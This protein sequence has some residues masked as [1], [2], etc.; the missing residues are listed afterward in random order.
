M[1]LA[2]AA[3]A[4]RLG[5]T[6]RA[7]FAGRTLR[8]CLASHARLMPGLQAGVMLRL[9]E[10]NGLAHWSH[11]LAGS[12]AG[13]AKVLNEGIAGFVASAV[14]AVTGM[15]PEQLTV[16]LPHRAEAPLRI[17][18]E[19]LG[20]RV[21][22]GARDAIV[23]TFDCRWLDRANLLLGPAPPG[24]DPVG[25]LPR[26]FES[27]AFS[28]S[29]GLADAARSLGLS[30]RSL[31]RRLG[32]LGTSFEA[33]VDAWR[34]RQAC[35]QLATASLPVGTIGRA[36]GYSDPAHFVRAFRRWEGRTPLAFRHA[37]QHAGSTASA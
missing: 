22:F 14:K 25:A 26:L 1:D 12:D 16:S 6:G 33:L 30:P 34:H 13:H 24:E 5:L 20:A 17:Y 11:R 9:E 18:E 3:D 23:W 29:L 21:T 8:E 31:Q 2:A 15:A 35:A 32:A 37:A 7:L 4:G 27:S 28:G 10:S 36:L 19:K